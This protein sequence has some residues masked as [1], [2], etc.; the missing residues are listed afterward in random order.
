MTR[1]HVKY[2][3]RVVMAEP[4]DNPAIPEENRIGDTMADLFGEIEAAA[5][6]QEVVSRTIVTGTDGRPRRVRCAARSLDPTR[7]YATARRWQITTPDGETITVCSAACLLSWICHEGLPAG[8]Q[9]AEG[10]TTTS[11][12]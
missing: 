10:G 5:L 12:G 11:E 7:H 4:P 9:T 2:L 6:D 1:Q 3:I 8:A